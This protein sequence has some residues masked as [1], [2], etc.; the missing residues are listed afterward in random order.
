MSHDL[1]VAARSWLFVP[2]TRPERFAKAAASGADLVVV[3]LEDAVPPEKKADARAAATDW[4]AHG[5]EAAVR[6]N[7]A[8]SEQH[9]NDVA[10]LA[11]LRGVR[12]V[13]LPMTASAAAI[14]RM[15]DRLGPDVA[16]VPQIETALGLVRVVDLAGAPGV[17]RLAFGH[18]DFAFDI[19]ASPEPEAMAWARSSLVVASR[20]AGLAAPVDSITADLDDE[21]A[22]R[23]DAVRA[24]SLGFTGKLCVHPRQVAAVNE[25]MTPTAEEIAGAERVLAA[26]TGGAVRVDGQM[27]DAPVV[28]RARRI[29]AR[30]RSGR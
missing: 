8:D 14:A 16:L 9:A 19:D 4:L 5:G 12:A 20:A 1:T 22:T 18:I 21:E 7:P 25:A 15:H 30:A 11:G 28:A 10:A 27:V 6:V 2:A 24:R 26:D 29:M 3:D 23:G 17:V 13:M